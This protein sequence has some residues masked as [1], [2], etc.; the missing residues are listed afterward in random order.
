MSV[1]DAVVGQERAVA[2][3]SQ[4][5]HRR[6]QPSGLAHAWLVTGPPGSGRSVAAR[7]FAA[8]LQCGDDGCGRCADC[9]ETL[10]GTHPDVTV[11]ATD[12]MQV[13]KDTVVQLVRRASVSPTR[14]RYVVV[15]VEDADRLRDVAANMLLKEIE[16]PPPH[17]VWVL[18]APSPEDLLPTIRSRCRQVTLGVPRAD[19]V[20]RV[21]VDRHGVSAGEAAWAAAASQGHIGVARRLAVDPDA[22]RRRREVLQ[23]PNRAVGV[24]GAVEAA[25]EL[26][27]IATEE[28]TAAV[29]AAQEAENA[30]WLR[31]MGVQTPEELP[32][33]VRAQWRELQ[34][35]HKRQVRRSATDGLDR[36]LLDLLSLY[37]DVLLVQAG[38]PVPLVNADMRAD[39]ER[40][41]RRLAPADVLRVC[42][43]I[44][45]TR[46]RL[47]QNAALPLA[48]E[49][50]TVRLGDPAA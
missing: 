50:M 48:L 20:A 46:R 38:A 35:Q 49:A 6:L 18:C 8:A 43:V 30:S 24:P 44:T 32:R 33:Q 21:L 42:D 39:V 28:S 2:T 31:T 4:A 27:D 19:A 40:L 17:T 29:E 7:A 36:A 9:A 10:A 13:R 26:R 25:Q 5:V 41:A 34:E 47:T 16:E 14:G 22:R 1:W 23:V 12:E 11:L 37:R 3:L 45:T 15:V